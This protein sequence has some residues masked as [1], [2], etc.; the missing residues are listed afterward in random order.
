MIAVLWLPK[1]AEQT[2][3]TR[4]VKIVKPES[5]TS[6]SL[7]LLGRFLI[8]AIEHRGPAGAP[9]EGQSGTPASRGLRN[10]IATHVVSSLTKNLPGRLRKRGTPSSG[11]VVLSGASGGSMASR[12]TVPH[13]HAIV[14]IVRPL[15]ES[16]FN[17]RDKRPAFQPF[18]SE[19]ADRRWLSFRRGCADISSEI[20][21]RSFVRERLH[22]V[23]VELD[24]ETLL[25]YRPRL[26]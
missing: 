6:W 18:S 3:R 20:S 8:A 19:A 22:H 10:P 14:V 2:N 7:T 17:L 24:G 4:P 25:L 15:L 16:M 1:S 5:R 26:T 9:R 12:H 13:A 11:N 21:W 23:A